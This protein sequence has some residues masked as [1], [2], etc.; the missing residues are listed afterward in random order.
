[1]SASPI[2]LSKSPTGRPPQ[3]RVALTVNVSPELRERLARLSLTT[4]RSLTDLVRAALTEHIAV[5][6]QRAE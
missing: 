5:A 3:P 1:M 2:I 4:G 6:E